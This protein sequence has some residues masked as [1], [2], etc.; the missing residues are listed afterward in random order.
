MKKATVMK[1]NPTI[2]YLILSTIF[3]LNAHQGFAQKNKSTEVEIIQTNMNGKGKT[4][5]LVFE[6]GPEHNHPMMAAWLEDEQGSYLQTLFVNESV[7]KGYFKHADKSGGHW[8]A[9]E[10][11]RPASLPVWAHK[12]GVESV[13]GHFM[14]TMDQPVP[15]AYT[16]ATPTTDFILESKSD[17]ALPEK[18][19]VM[20]E[21]NQSWDWNDYWTNNKFPDDEDY[22]TSS[23]PS[24]VYAVD[25][26]RDDLKSSYELRVI[27]HG[28]CSG[29]NGQ[30]NSEI[31]TLTTALEIV[32]NVHVQIK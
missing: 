15:D 6:A 5:E 27:G 10:L 14:P 1:R 25:I 28:H 18:F 19:S 7:A 4:I 9:G 12:R 26:D 31:E 16:G 2:I 30:I 23:Q 13:D 11:V 29:K 17:K 8:H 20:F 22:K 3:L 21:I 32:E 24:V